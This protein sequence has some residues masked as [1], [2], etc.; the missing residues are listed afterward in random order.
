MRIRTTAAAVVLAAAATL[1][2]AG[3]AQA[4]AQP[5]GDRDCAGF[6]TQV[7]PEGVGPVNPR[8]CS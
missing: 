5:P 4:Q 2:M 6:V 7:I 3:L 1:P 8:S